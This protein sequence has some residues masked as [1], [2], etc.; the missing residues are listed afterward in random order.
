[1]DTPETPESKMPFDDVP[2]DA[3]AAHE[4]LMQFIIS[5]LILVIVVSGTLNILLLRLWKNSKDDLAVLR[6]DHDNFMRGFQQNEG[7]VL[8]KLQ[9]FG[10][11]HPDYVPVLAKYG[12]KPAPGVSAPPSLSAPSTNS[13]SGKK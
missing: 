10:A 6:P 3:R 2:E 13:P 8:S 9:E 7:V 11:N 5:V 1:M 4:S 12:L